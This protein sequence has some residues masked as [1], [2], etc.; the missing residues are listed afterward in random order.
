MPRK[1]K[2]EVQKVV[3][4]VNH[5]RDL[6]TAAGMSQWDLGKRLDVGQSTISAWE[7]GVSLPTL[8]MV[9]QMMDVFQVPFH[10]VVSMEKEEG[11]A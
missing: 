2:T 11:E 4:F 5:V 7:N 3:K 1:I 9:G 8:R 10:A 6:R